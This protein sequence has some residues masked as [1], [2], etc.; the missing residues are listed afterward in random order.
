[1]NALAG[2]LKEWFGY[3]RRERRSACFLLLVIVIIIITRI[4]VPE[5]TVP[6]GMIPLNIDDYSG[7]GLKNSTAWFGSKIKIREQALI[8]K[9]IVIDINNWAGSSQLVQYWTSTV[10]KNHQIMDLSYG[11]AAVEQL[12]KYIPACRN[13]RPDKINGYCWF[14]WCVA[15]KINKAELESTSY[16]EKEEAVHEVQSCRNNQKPG[17][18]GNNKLISRERIER[19]MPILI[20]PSI[21]ND[22]AM[23]CCF[24][25]KMALVWVWKMI[26][27]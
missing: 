19:I 13:V 26:T 2:F 7:E 18:S 16:I 20:L 17:G 1:M 5:K 27:G 21:S 11:Y 8:F 22:E 24:Y 6:V 25:C 4:V 9:R 10:G 3:T 15:D 14:I 12:R 23:S